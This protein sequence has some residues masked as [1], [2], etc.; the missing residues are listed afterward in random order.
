M[1]SGQLGNVVPDALDLFDSA[2]RLDPYPGYGRLRDT[3]GRAAVRLGDTEVT[4]LSRYADCAAVLQS[5][6]W[7]H[8]NADRLSPFWDQETSLP[9]SFIRMDP[10]DHR[11]LRAL[12]NKA[13]SARMV[14]DLA[15]MI[16]R[17]VDSLVDHAIAAGGLDVVRDLSAPLALAMVGQ[18]LLGVPARDADLLRAWELAIARGTDPEPLLSAEEIA[19]RDEAGAGVVGYLADLVRRRRAEP[20]DDLLS[21]LIAVEEAGDALSA[22]EVIGICVLLLIAGMETSINL[23]GNGVRALLA[24]PDQLELLRRRPELTGSAVEEILRYDTPTQFTM[25]V[26]LTD[27]TVGGRAFRRGDGVIVLMAS[28]G[29]DAAVFAE[30]DRLD[31]TRYAEPGRS[32]RHLGFSL[33]AHYCL[34]AP[35]ARLEASTAIGTLVRRA[36]GLRLATDE[37][38][39]Y[40][41]SIIH[42]GP[43]SLPVEL[44]TT[45]A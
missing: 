38:V 41:P 34:G 42:R 12:V 20:R 11:R 31:L 29:R 40:Q 16:T 21:R 5:P 6:A 17:L 7:G 33:G 2:H 25:R 28:A 39:S 24:H 9:G 1:T 22:P 37:P 18:R 26:A 10:P 23:V 4:L 36:P 43:R 8:G 45:A 32:P 30:P 15:P 14:A 35:L 19:G 3:P 44:T 13:F 27:T